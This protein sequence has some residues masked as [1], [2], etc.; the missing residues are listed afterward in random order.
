MKRSLG[1][2]AV[3]VLLVGLSSSTFAERWGKPGANLAKG[4]WSL[5]TEYNYIEEEL[6]LAEPEGMF[7]PGLGENQA[8]RSQLLV[9][10]GYGL[11]DKIEGF[12]KIGGTASDISDVFISS[13]PDPNPN[14]VQFNADMCGE[15]EFTIVGGLAITLL[16]QG[17]FRLG[18]VGQFTYFNNDDTHSALLFQENFII[19]GIDANV[20]R[21]EGALLASYQMGKITP[22][23]GVCMLIT[24]SD[25][26]FRAY[27]RTTTPMAELDIDIDQEDWFG[28]VVGANCEVVPNVNVGLELTHVSEGVGLSVGV[29]CAL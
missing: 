14:S 1:V 28:M 23:G 7:W 6:E 5:G 4:Q 19:Q 25:A 22:Y 3:L 13:M 2:L 9:R 12:L 17:N 20:F 18:T 10:V 11:T 16:E 8:V 15:M 24:D 27:G 26:R 21:F 29:N